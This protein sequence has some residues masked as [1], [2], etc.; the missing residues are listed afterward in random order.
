MSVTLSLNKDSGQSMRC[1]CCLRVIRFLLGL[2]VYPE[3]R[4]TMFFGNVVKFI[5][6]YTTLYPRR[7]YYSISWDSFTWINLDTHEPGLTIYS[8]NYVTLFLAAVKLNQI[9]GFLTSVYI[10]SFLK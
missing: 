1:A 5:P 3:D 8:N 7:Y 10:A 6:D 4:S 9:G 2:F